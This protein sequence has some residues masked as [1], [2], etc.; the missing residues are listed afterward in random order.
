MARL[1]SASDGVHSLNRF[2]SPD[3]LKTTGEAGGEPGVANA[4]GVDPLKHDWKQIIA[5][6]APKLKRIHVRVMRAEIM[7]SPNRSRMIFL[8][9]V[10]LYEAGATR[11]EVAAVVWRS[12]YFVSKHGHNV[13]RLESELGRISDY[14]ETRGRK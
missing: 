7:D 11:D 9:A 13:D 14:L 2:P 8:I 5:K 6:Y 1:I 12:P 4:D 3:A 10:H